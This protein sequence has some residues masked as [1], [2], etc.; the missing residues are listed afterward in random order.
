MRFDLGQTL[1][2]L[3]LFD[4][5]H[6]RFA[7]GLTKHRAAGLADGRQASLSPFLRTVLPQLAHQGAVRQEDEIHMP[8]LALATPELTITMPNAACRPDGRSLFLSS[9]CDRP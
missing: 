5:P 6:D 4:H 8:G 9:A 3:H 2:L 7:Q 1:P